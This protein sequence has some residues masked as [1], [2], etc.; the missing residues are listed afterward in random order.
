MRAPARRG[1]ARVDVLVEERHVRA[2]VAE[3]GWWRA[4]GLAALPAL[5]TR[6]HGAYKYH[7]GIRLL[8]IRGPAPRRPPGAALMSDP[9]TARTMPAERLADALADGDPDRVR[10]ISSTLMRQPPDAE[11]SVIGA[12]GYAIGLAARTWSTRAYL[13]PSPQRERD[14]TVLALAAEGVAAMRRAAGMEDAQ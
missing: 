14:R 1:P 12:I 3:R 9:D 10:A 11:S 2:V 13:G 7:A 4:R 5:E 8:R 6:L